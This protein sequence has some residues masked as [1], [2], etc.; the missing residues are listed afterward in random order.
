M[1]APGLNSCPRY[2][3]LFYPRGDFV[4]NA[5]DVEYLPRRMLHDDESGREAEGSDPESFTRR[6]S[7]WLEILKAGGSDRK[8][9]SFGFC[10]AG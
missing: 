9:H 7:R 10:C 5:A 2:E 4:S 8:P 1:M 6:Q 3:A